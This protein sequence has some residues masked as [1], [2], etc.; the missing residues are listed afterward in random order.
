VTPQELNRLRDTGTAVAFN[1]VASLW[2]GNAVA[3]ALQMSAL[4]IRFGL[5][6]DGT[7][8]DAFRLLDAAEASQRTAFGLATGDSSCGG[9]WLW[10]DH[11]TSAGAGAV[12][13]G[14]VTG[15]IAV[16]READFL[17][18][19]LETPEMTPSHDRA[20]E[21]VRFGNRDQIE[22]IFTAGRLRIWQGW[23]VD[24]DGRALL[25][26][27][28]AVAQEA[29]A[30]APIQRVHRVSTRHRALCMPPGDAAAVSV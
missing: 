9:G 24:W 20:W 29:V 3:A 1:P 12:G 8:S 7:R 26:E 10:L 27:V 15:E 4:G 14:A 2:K 30:R 22:A 5:G 21:L 25:R 11:G 16:G 17:L 19:D 18:I 23:P 6:T 28:A 13:L